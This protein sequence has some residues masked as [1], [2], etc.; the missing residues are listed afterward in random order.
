M[1]SLLIKRTL[2]FKL[3]LIILSF[4]LMVLA[5][6]GEPQDNKALVDQS[7]SDAQVSD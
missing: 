6:A 3:I 4:G 1:G 5:W 7:N 2:V